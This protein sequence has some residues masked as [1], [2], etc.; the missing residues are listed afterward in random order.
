MTL[1]FAILFVLAAF[2]VVECFAHLSPKDQANQSGKAMV[3]TQPLPGFPLGMPANWD[4]NKVSVLQ[5]TT[6]FVT[7][8]P[9]CFCAPGA[10]RGV[11]TLTN[12]GGLRKF[13]RL[14]Q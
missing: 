5:V 10:W 3:V 11:M 14:S 6:D 2:L 8:T 12:D 13:A 1:R 9:V 7:W 4:T